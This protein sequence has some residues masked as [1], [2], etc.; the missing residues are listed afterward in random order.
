MLYYKKQNLKQN[1]KVYKYSAQ[2][3]LVLHVNFCNKG[4]LR[5]EVSMVIKLYDKI[6]NRIE[7][8]D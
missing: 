2:K 6:S 7:D 3:E 8:L 4:R 1:V 5:S